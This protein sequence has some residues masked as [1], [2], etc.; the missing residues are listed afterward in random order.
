MSYFH[1]LY[2]NLVKVFFFNS[3]ENKFV[4][5]EINAVLLVNEGGV[6]NNTGNENTDFQFY[7][8]MSFVFSFLNTFISKLF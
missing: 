1:L 7:Y 4:T 3:T 2:D 5:L 8:S 6:F